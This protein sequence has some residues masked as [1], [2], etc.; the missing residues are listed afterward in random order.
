MLI[1]AYPEV[2]C[3]VPCFNEDIEVLE[4]S[5]RSLKN[6]S[7]TNFEC[8]VIDESTDQKIANT[9][10]N[11]CESDE[12][13]TYIHPLG[14]VGLA[15]SL[16]IGIEMAKG[17]FIARFDSDDICDVNRFALQVEFLNKNP[18]IGV[19]GSALDII[20]NEGILTARRAYPLKHLEIEKKFIFSNSMA[21]PTV[22]FRK[23]VLLFSVRAYDPSFRYSEDLD[24]WLRL[25]NHNVKFANLALPLVKY[26][27]QHTSRNFQHW[28]YN[29]K[30][31]IKNFSSPHKLLKIVAILGIVFWMILPA[32]IQR[33]LFKV[34]QLRKS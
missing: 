27:Q 20:N 22:M 18:E 17:K 34:I 32:K 31:R 4:I 6:Q 29:L 8:I 9:C 23:S 16:N 25:I 19:V 15:G 30:A 2:S 14:R 7:F 13:F 3:L 1:A 24:F 10:K 26:R 28:K 33:P 11:F 12:R 5:L 21:H